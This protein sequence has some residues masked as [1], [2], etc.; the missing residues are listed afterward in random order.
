MSGTERPPGWGDY[1]K[2]FARVAVLETTVRTMRNETEKHAAALPEDV[3]AA[4]TEEG[5]KGDPGGRSGRDDGR[6][7]VQESAQ[8]SA[9]PPES[10]RPV[11]G[12][13]ERA[14]FGERF[15]PI[16]DWLK[17]RPESSR[18]FTVRLD[19]VTDKLVYH[20]AQDGVYFVDDLYDNIEQYMKSAYYSM[21]RLDL[22]AS[23][24]KERS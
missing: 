24:K 21:R 6:S 3:R 7:G 5:T 11:P 17:E 12:A 4:G 23:T 8:T 16:L 14:P 20:L 13:S 19:P 10:S 9:E 1:N 2:L 22:I 15:L 18:S